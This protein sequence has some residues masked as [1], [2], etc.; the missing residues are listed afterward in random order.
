[1]KEPL[2][3]LIHSLDNELTPQEA[4][5]LEQALS[6]SEA[7]RQE[8]ERLLEMRELIGTVK[9]EPDHT[10]VN[11]V[12]MRIEQAKD[13]VFSTVII[14]LFPKVAAAC[15]L[16]FI[17]TLAGIYMTEGTLSTDAIIGI[18][19]MTMEEALTITEL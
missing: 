13:P 1:M 19:D 18:Q 11:K 3:L 6:N 15:V 7:L 17:V 9:M 2:Q 16:L 14:N 8:K 12:M 5:Q 10:F 4:Q